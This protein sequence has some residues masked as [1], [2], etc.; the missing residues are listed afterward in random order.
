MYIQ[1]IFGAEIANL[2]NR[3][4]VDFGRDEKEATRTE[5]I[6]PDNAYSKNLVYILREK[7][8]GYSASE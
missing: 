4:A 6:R 5:R 3:K 1:F 8:C 2:C 7:N